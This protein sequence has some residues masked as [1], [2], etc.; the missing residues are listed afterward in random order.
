MVKHRPLISIKFASKTYGDSAL[1]F[2]TMVLKNVSLEIHDGEFVMIFGPSG[3]G[4]STLLNLMA[5]LENPTAGKVMVR[6]RDLSHFDDMQLARYHRLKLGMVFQSFNLIRSLNVWENVSL[7]MTANGVNYKNRRRTTQRLLKLFNIDKYMDRHVS[8]M[9]GGQQQR[10]AI[11]RA[12][13]NNPYFMLVDEPTGNLDSQSAEDVM[14][15]FQG[16]HRHAKHTIVM[17][18]HNPAQLKYASRVI[19]IQDGDIV[20]EERVKSDGTFEEIQATENLKVLT[21]F[22]DDPE[23]HSDKLPPVS[24]H[25]DVPTPPIPTEAKSRVHRVKHYKLDGTVSAHTELEVIHNPHHELQIIDEKVPHGV[26]LPAVSLSASTPNPE[27][28]PV[29]TSEAQSASRP[30]AAPPAPSSIPAS[31]DHPGS[32]VGQL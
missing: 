5:G 4:K 26:V 1:D 19:H 30:F 16:L 22:K 9:S 14:K 2:S 28:A 29:A 7:P 24:P 13:V 31:R 6:G 8:E 12:L 10:V 25:A 11:A 20:K 27:S 17:V 3:S 21:G 15:I 32:Q 18:T 23:H